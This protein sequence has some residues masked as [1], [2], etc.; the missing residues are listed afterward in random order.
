MI[1]ILNTE[2][3]NLRSFGWVQDSADFKKLCDVVAIFD[4]NSE[5]HK[6]LVDDK[7]PSLVDEMDGRKVLIAELNKRPLKIEYGKLIGTAF[8]PRSK[9]RCN[10]IIQA[11]LPGQSRKFLLDWPANNFIRWAHALGFIKYNYEDDTFEITKN[12]IKLSESYN[13]HISEE[14]KEKLI[15]AI[16]SYPPAIRVLSLLSIENSHL[17][18]FEIG[19]KLGFV[20]QKGFT[21][22]PQDLL[23]VELVNA[24]NPK[25]KKKIRANWEG[26]SDKY[27]RMI[28]GWLEKLGLVEKIPKK[29]SVVRGEKTYIDKINQAYM[30]TGYGL[31]EL[32]NS[33][34]N[35]RHKRIVKNVYWELFSTKE[36]N[37]NYLRIRRS[38]ILKFL[39]ENK[40]K[41][42]LEDIQKYLVDNNINC[43]IGTISDD[44]KGIIN[45][46]IEIDNIGE[47]YICN[48]YI[49]DF[50]ILIP[51]QE[52]TESP[53]EK[54]K[55]KLREKLE[56]LPHEYL[57]LVDLA[58]DGSQN[59]IFEIKTIE[60]FIKIFGFE[61]M[62]LGGSRE[63]DGLIYTTELKENYGVVVDTKA[64][65]P[66]YN[67]PIN[68]ADEMKRYLHE[69]QVRD[70]DINS[71][72]WWLNFE[73]NIS[74]FYYLFVSG[75]F[76]GRFQERLENIMRTTGINGAAL[77]VENMLLCA[78]AVMANKITLKNIGDEMFNNEEYIY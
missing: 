17:T 30:I 56:F 34:G 32:N 28:A 37:K 31:R 5:F 60:L 77:G 63:P 52:L 15:D 49:S 67:L 19:K 62:H 20:G 57:S 40:K 64:Y 72:S 46:G 41:V 50:S 47:K 44:I 70:L 8:T 58:Y 13:N 69:N 9:S 4:E 45:I 73:D 10:G 61:G 48:D 22:L 14:I 39:L 38:L 12:G 26:S 24:K 6:S 53:L 65:N 18:K 1:S 3:R 78:D 16:L 55:D 36:K 2:S 27:A 23:I 54:T 43:S 42:F 66:G 35:S 25:N 76:I 21:S 7:I 74:I 71:N 29:I 33:K 75:K 11:A 68:Q 59:K 51:N